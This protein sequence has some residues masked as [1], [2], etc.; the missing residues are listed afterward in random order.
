MSPDT[1]NA[2]K[3]YGAGRHVFGAGN[4]LGGDIEKYGPGS[5]EV[6]ADSAI[7]GRELRVYGGV[8]EIGHANALGGGAALTVKPGGRCEYY[9]TGTIADG[10]IG[11]TFD[12]EQDTGAF[13]M[14][15]CDMTDEG[16]EFLDTSGRSTLTDGIQLASH[17]SPD[18]VVVRLAGG[19]KM[20]FS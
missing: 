7:S 6:A 14:S 3:L 1:G 4:T 10:H 13:T 20:S 12:G 2:I 16:A 18:D 19:K 9:G 17:L 15:D 5:V 11:G 8:A